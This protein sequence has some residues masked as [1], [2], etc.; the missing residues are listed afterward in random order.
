MLIDTHCHLFKEDYSDI[1]DVIQRAY[2]N[3]VRMVVVNGCNDKTNKEVLEL[4]KKYDIVYGALG[5]QPEEVDG[6]NDDS[7]QFITDHIDDEKILAVGEIGLDYHYECDKKRQKEIFKKQLDIAYKHNKPVIIH[8][9]DCIQETYDILKE[10]KVKGIL[11]CYS[12][13]VEMAREFN[14]LGFLLGIGGIC[15]FKNAQNIVKVIK[16]VDLEYIVLETDA[17]YLTP[18]PYRGGRNEPSNVVVIAE[19]ISG[20][21]S[22]SFKEVCETTTENF[23]RLFDK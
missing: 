1:E 10:S 3:G 7:I 15:T 20:L 21:K 14:K 2:D 16:E 8:S 9:R 11:H 22:I 19:K 5:I 18:E 6:V 17:P 13:S 23:L 12:G 4:V